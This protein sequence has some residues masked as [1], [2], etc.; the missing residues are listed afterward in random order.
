MTNLKLIDHPLD[1]KLY[2]IPGNEK[3]MPP[4]KPKSPSK[5]TQESTVEE[6]SLIKNP[7]IIF[8][9]S[10][11]NIQLELRR[12]SYSS[13]VIDSS[14]H[15]KMMSKRIC[16]RHDGI[17]TIFVPVLSI[18]MDYDLFYEIASYLIVNGFKAMPLEVDLV[19][20]TAKKKSYQ[21][22]IKKNQKVLKL[23]DELIASWIAVESVRIGKLFALDCFPL[24][25]LETASTK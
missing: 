21:S 12:F 8:L 13:L 25:K 9:T 18:D 6:D 3:P 1:I 23:F 14:D 20:V 15:F 10:S 17:P 2:L 11:K 24:K 22:Y 5:E 16:E 4:K 19:K 7:E